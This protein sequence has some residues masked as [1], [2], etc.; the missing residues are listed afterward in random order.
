MGRRIFSFSIVFQG[1]FFFFFF[2]VG[3]SAPLV[4][5]GSEVVHGPV[6]HP[7]TCLSTGESKYGFR[8]THTS[9]LGFLSRACLARLSELGLGGRCWDALEQFFSLT[10]GCGP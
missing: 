8:E 2:A 3:T 7:L 1:G 4:Q 6:F 5:S 10:L 9:C